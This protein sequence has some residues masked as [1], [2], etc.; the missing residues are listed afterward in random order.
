MKTASQCGINT[1]SRKQLEELKKALGAKVK[2]TFWV[3]KTPT[4]LMIRIEYL[5]GD[6]AKNIVQSD[7]TIQP[8]DCS[9]GYESFVREDIDISEVEALIEEQISIENT[10]A[11]ITIE[12]EED[13]IE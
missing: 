4:I 2:I 1:L 13:D 7:G 9:N 12:D 10:P 3:S 6:R 11:K 5:N 8:G